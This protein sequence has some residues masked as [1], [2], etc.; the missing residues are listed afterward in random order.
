MNKADLI[1]LGVSEEIAGQV[2]VLHGKDIEGHKARIA[3]I[4]SESAG[5]KSQLSE[6]GN[7]IEGFKKMDVEGIRSAADQWKMKAEAAQADTAAQVNG[8]KFNY[9]LESGLSAAKAKNLTA[10]KSL[11]QTEG[12]KLG[13]DGIIT[14]LTEQLER[15]KTEND[16]LFEDNQPLPKIVTGGTSKSIMGDPVIDAARRAAGLG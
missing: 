1:A 4:E 5:L 13:D 6:A 3:A 8:L 11:L 12:L 10:V 14:G 15:I 2:V 16:Y 7:A 9:A